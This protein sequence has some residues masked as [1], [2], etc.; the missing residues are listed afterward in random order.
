MKILYVFLVNQLTEI[1]NDTLL[2]WSEV[3]EF[4]Y[5]NVIR[6]KNDFNEMLYFFMI[7]FSC[8]FYLTTNPDQTVHQYDRRIRVFHNEEYHEHKSL[9]VVGFHFV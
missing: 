9:S 8:E 7:S 6:S 4:E 3:G 5:W 1:K 2:F